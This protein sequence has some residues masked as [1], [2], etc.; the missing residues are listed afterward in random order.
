MTFSLI[1]RCAETGAFGIVVSSSS[2]AVAARC[3]FARAR[4]GA[5]ATQN[6]TDPRIGPRALGLL[7]TG[8]PARS[9]LDRIIETTPHIAYRQV[10]VIDGAGGTAA[11]SGPETLGT[12]ATAEGGNCVAAGN[13]LADEAVVAAMVDA[14]EARAARSFGKR[15]VRALRAGQAAGGEAGPVRSAGLLIQAAD[16]PWPVADLRVDDAD[17]P[18]GA[19]TALWERWKPEMD[20]YVTRALDPSRAPSYGVPGDP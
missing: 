2:V 11:F 1:A 19:L 8:L 15:L 18:I 20:S 9:V 5:V 10:A 7:E 6:I 4:V 17:D 3:A 12:Y 13:L 14:F 16:V